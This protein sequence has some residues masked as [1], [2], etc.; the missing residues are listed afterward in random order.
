MRSD[1]YL[2]RP[3]GAA[4]GQTSGSSEGIVET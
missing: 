2:A 3:H 1:A 4:H